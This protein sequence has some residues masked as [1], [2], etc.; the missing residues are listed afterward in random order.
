[1]HAPS[2]RVVVYVLR[3][4]RNP[5]RHYVGLT[6][7]LA[8]RLARHNAGQNVHTARDRP[9]NIVVSLEF[10]SEQAAVRF[11]HYLK[12]ESGRTFAKRHF[13]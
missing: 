4:D 10:T 9:W 2:K 6:A 1:M 11:E 7:D 3:S 12:S 8:R 5:A 13:S